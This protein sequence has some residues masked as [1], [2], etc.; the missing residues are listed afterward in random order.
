MVIRSRIVLSIR[1]RC[2]PTTTGRETL[3][4]NWVWSFLFLTETPESTPAREIMDHLRNLAPIDLPRDL[5]TVT[6]D[7]YCSRASRTGHGEGGVPPSL[8][9]GRGP[10]SRSSGGPASVVEPA[11]AGR[12]AR[13]GSQ[14]IGRRRRVGPPPSFGESDEGGLRSPPPLWGRVRVGGS[15]GWRR[16][17]HPPPY[18]PPQGGRAGEEPSPEATAGQHARGRVAMH[19]PGPVVGAV[20]HFRG[21][22][23]RTGP[24]LR[25]FRGDVCAAPMSASPAPTTMH[26]C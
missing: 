25:S 14:A 17:L 18:P 9:V 2:L 20:G 13:G 12:V 1:A 15:S 24:L 4:F 6:L 10:H 16:S 3:G 26:P 19:R 21:L 11:G 5:L 22:G 23:E 7:D 8:R